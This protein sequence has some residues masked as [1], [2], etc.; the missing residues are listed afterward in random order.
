[1]IAGAIWSL[2]ILKSDGIKNTG[3]RNRQVLFCVVNAFPEP[4]E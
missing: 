3:W 2:A 1:M 4:K